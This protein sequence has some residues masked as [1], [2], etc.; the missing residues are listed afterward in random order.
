[1]MP[2]ELCVGCEVHLGFWLSWFEAR[3]EIL[4]SFTALVQANPGYQLVVTGHS[5]G[6]AIALLAAAEL[7]NQG[8]N[9]ALVSPS[10]QTRNLPQP[11]SLTYKV[12]YTYG[13]PRVGNPAFSSWVDSKPGA[14]DFRI[15]HTDDTV[16][17]LGPLALGYDHI[18]PEY[19]IETD[20]AT[21]STTQIVRY[22]GDANLDGNAGTSSFDV[23]AHLNYFGPISKCASFQLI[24]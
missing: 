21:P 6:G 3:T 16:P 2:I 1:M 10:T 9:V 23:A 4:D 15:T 17:R 18:S 19:H 12:Q 8:L 14:G 22:N 5:L 13:Q 24:K 7:R 11:N 20:S